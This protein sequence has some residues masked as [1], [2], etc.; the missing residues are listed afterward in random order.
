MSSVHAKRTRPPE[1]PPG[2]RKRPKIVVESVLQKRDPAQESL[3]ATVSKTPKTSSALKDSGKASQ[4]KEGE[5]KTGVRR[6]VIDTGKSLGG[7]EK[8]GPKIVILRK[9]SSGDSGEVS[10]TPV[11]DEKKGMRDAI[12]S[13]K[14]RIVIKAQAGVELKPKGAKRYA[15]IDPGAKNY[16]IYIDQRQQDKVPQI[17][18]WEKW[19]MFEEKQKVIFSLPAMKLLTQNLD[20][21][22]SVLSTCDKVLVE[23]QVRKNKQMLKIEQHTLTYLQLRLPESVKIVLVPNKWKYTLLGCP[24]GLTP[25]RRKRWSVAKAKEILKERGQMDAVEFLEEQEKDDDFA[26]TFTTLEACLKKMGRS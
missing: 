8:K 19:T 12:K 15:S 16:A 11:L 1:K 26:E 3:S 14:P 25:Y 24:S 2:E 9:K 23:V 5:V 21:L 7:E 4:P 22:L 10:K 17:L 18:K 6:I 20:T 13:K